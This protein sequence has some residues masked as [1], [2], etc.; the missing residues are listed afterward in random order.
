[1]ETRYM[2]GRFTAVGLHVESAAAIL[3]ARPCQ[4]QHAAPFDGLTRRPGAPYDGAAEGITLGVV[5]KVGIVGG[6]PAGAACAE[7]LARQPGTEVTLFEAREGHE[8]P[9]GGGIPS[10]ALREFPALSDGSLARRVVR[11]LIL[12]SPSGR[13]ARLE[14]PG[15]IRVFRRSELDAFLRDRA[16][17]AGAKIARA[18]VTRVSPADRAGWRVDAEGAPAAAFDHLVG[19]DGVNGI[20]RRACEPATLDREMTLA[21]FAYLPEGGPDE[22]V[23][24]FLD[25]GRGYMWVFPRLDH[26]SVGICALRGALTRARM[27]EDLESFIHGRFGAHA[28]ARVRGYFIPSTLRPP[29]DTRGRSVALIG[30]AGGFV[31]PLT[32]EGIAHAMRSGLSA[33]EGLLRH[34]T[35][36]TPA[37][38]GEMAI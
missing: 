38:P 32:R 31:D 1:M 9:C 12:I 10:A 28:P 2:M 20:V 15:G 4:R 23:L 33:A 3:P 18:R 14:A 21:L 26:V 29:V 19:A 16:A 7:A 6:G 13:E 17:R 22:M 37:L 34:G 11:R 5:A 35:L 25:R 30:D 27:E 24:K 8:K 36:R